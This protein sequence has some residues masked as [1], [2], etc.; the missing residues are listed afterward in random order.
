MREGH[1]WQRLK[2]TSIFLCTNK[3]QCELQYLLKTSALGLT[4]LSQ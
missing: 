2:E 4:L 1:K 3:L